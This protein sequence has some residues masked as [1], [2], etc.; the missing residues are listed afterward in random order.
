MGVK[1]LGKRQ[2]ESEEAVKRKEVSTM[3]T[4][5]LPGLSWGR[6]CA[7]ASQTALHYFVLVPKAR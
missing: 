7:C 1:R 6:R 2:Q 5:A 4:A 3:Q